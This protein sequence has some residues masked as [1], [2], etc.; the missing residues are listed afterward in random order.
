MDLA[1]APAVGVVFLGLAEDDVL[2]E[3]GVGVLFEPRESIAV[4]FD[5]RDDVV[6]TVLVHVVDMHLGSAY[7]EGRLMELPCAGGGEVLGLFIPTVGFEDVHAAVAVDVAG[8]VAVRILEDLLVVLLGLFGDRVELRLAERV[9]PIDLRV[10]ELATMAA[11]VVLRVLDGIAGVAEELRLAVAVDVDE[12]RGFTVGDV[13]DVMNGP[14]A[15]FALRVL[16][17]EGG[18]TGEAEDQDVLPAVGVEVVGVGDEVVRVPRGAVEG[19]LVRALLVRRLDGVADALLEIGALPDVPTGSD[20][21]MAVMVEV[22]DRAAFGDE[23]LREGLLIE[24]DRSGDGTA[25]E[26][27]GEEGGEES[28]RGTIY[29][30]DIA[31][32]CEEFW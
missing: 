23:V 13:E 9:L 19:R 31:N 18:V 4:G 20:V 11:L 12:L 28:H 21:D 3:G 15:G 30:P 16:V 2:G 22:G 26:Q 7:A 25:A 14:G 6:T 10:A 29:T 27:D 1:E 24:R 32:G 5:A 8:A 17:D